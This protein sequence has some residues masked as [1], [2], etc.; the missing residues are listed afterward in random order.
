MKTP[1]ARAKKRFVTFTLNSDPDTVLCRSAAEHKAKRNRLPSD[2]CDFVWQMQ[3][4]KHT[5]KKRHAHAVDLW[6]V[7]PNKDTY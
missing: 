6:H 2:W 3:R 5:A 4:D 1:S 7:N